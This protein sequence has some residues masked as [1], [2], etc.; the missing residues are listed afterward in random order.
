MKIIIAST[1]VYLGETI[2]SWTGLKKATSSTPDITLASQQFYKIGPIIIPTY[3]ETPK[4]GRD[5]FPTVSG[6]ARTPPQL[7]SSKVKVLFHHTASL[8]PKKQ[9]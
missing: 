8:N 1:Q 4:A 6:K 3:D 7:P 5:H 9:W 2:E